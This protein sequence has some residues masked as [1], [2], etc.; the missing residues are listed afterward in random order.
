MSQDRIETSIKEMDRFLQKEESMK[1]AKDDLHLT[2]DEMWED[3]VRLLPDSFDPP[4]EPEPKED[5]MYKS[6]ESSVV[7]QPRAKVRL[8]GIVKKAITRAEK[9]LE[10]DVEQGK[11]IKFIPFTARKHGPYQVAKSS[12]NSDCKTMNKYMIDKLDTGHQS[13][14]GRMILCFL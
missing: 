13:P 12:L 7:Y 8:A 6:S 11:A 4:E 5:S 3:L 1:I 2:T 10:N 9:E 14:G